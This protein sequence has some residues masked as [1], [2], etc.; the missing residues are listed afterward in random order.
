MFGIWYECNRVIMVALNLSL[1]G[2]EKK[3][4]IA[5]AGV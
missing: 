4:P 2:K 5:T 3:D 1:V